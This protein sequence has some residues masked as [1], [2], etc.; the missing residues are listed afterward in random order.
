MEHQSAIMRI[1]NYY[2]ENGTAAFPA[3]TVSEQFFVGIL[4]KPYFTSE[5]EVPICGPATIAAG[6]PHPSTGSE[7]ARE[8]GSIGPVQGR[9]EC[10][11]K[12][13]RACI[14]GFDCSL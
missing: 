4:E 12:I 11:I 2:V 9:C 6:Q 10:V 13:D 5:T 7:A 1:F 8:K 3:S 14:K